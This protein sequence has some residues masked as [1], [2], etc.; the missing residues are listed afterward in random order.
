M[1]TA[2]ERPVTGQIAVPVDPARRPDVLLRRRAPEGHRV[3][4]WWLI[5][6]FVGV[7]LAVVG[8]MN[9]FPGG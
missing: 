9:F 6:A 3:S 1:S 8:L 2:S 5:G 4:A 7:S